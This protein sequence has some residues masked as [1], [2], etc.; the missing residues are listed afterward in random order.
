MG[1]EMALI[2]QNLHKLNKQML[3]E[4][5]SEFYLQKWYECVGL[6]DLFDFREGG[7][8]FDDEDED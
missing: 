5:Q 1:S 3:N 2:Y 4:T 7:A 8:E 6:K